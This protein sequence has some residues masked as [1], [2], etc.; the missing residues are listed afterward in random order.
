MEKIL[1]FNIILINFI[2]GNYIKINFFKDSYISPNYTDN[3]FFSRISTNIS[4][5]TPEYNITVE[6][7]TDSPYFV[8]KGSKLPNEYKQENSTSF[9]FI[10]YGNRYVYKNIYFHA[11]FFRENFTFNNQT[12]NLN[13]MMNWSN[14][15]ITYNYGLIGLQLYDLKFQEENIFIKQLYDKGII[16]NKMF[17]L[18]YENELRGELIIGDL[19]I[20][21]T[22]TNLLKGKKFKICNNTFITNGVLYGTIFDEIK[23]S[24]S[25]YFFKSF[26]TNE[27]N[28]IS[29][30]SS[31]YYG[32]IGSK[33][34][35]NFVNE[36]F[37]KKKLKNKS[38]W[39]KTIDDDKYYGYICYG[40]ID[41]SNIPSIKFYH[42]GLDYIFEIKN[43][44]MWINHNNMKYFIIYFSVNNQY[45]WILGQK[46]L[47]KYPMVFDGEKNLIGLYYNEDTENYFYLYIFLIFAIVML[48][49]IIYIYYKYIRPKC[50]LSNL[51]KK[52]ED[53]IE[54]DDILL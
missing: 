51:K 54:L 10:K 32:Y 7:S 20:N 18:L 9:Y 16:Q 2:K 35:N 8:V 5:G 45:S 29:L 34:Y 49:I 42:K 48:L 21:K 53:G 3:I 22:E 25:Y 19:P 46:F 44:E 4:F 31:A 38:C 33:E 50:I 52:L 39:I 14:K 1:I 23:F 30:F 6:I 13:S 12:I 37:F 26:K 17:S 11:V 27:L 40:N 36:T 28:Y 24:D 43:D 41:I 15:N 47:Q